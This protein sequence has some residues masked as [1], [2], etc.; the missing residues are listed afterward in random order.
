MQQQDSQPARIITID[1]KHLGNPQVIATYLLLGDEP[2]LVDP[3]P[4]AT[5]PNLEAGLATQGL[6]LSDIRTILLTHI[7]LDH[8][9]ATGTIVARHPH[10][11]VYVHERGAGHIIDPSRLLN[12]A[13][14]LYGSMMDTLWGDILPVR[15]DA[16]TTLQGGETLAVGRRTVRV[17][18]AP[19]HAKHHVIYL[20]EESGGAFVG[21]NG[22]VRLPGLHFT[23]PATPPPDVDLDAWER[24]L[25]LLE[26]L[27]PDW[28]LLTH[29]GAYPD[30]LHHLRDYRERLLRWGEYVRQGLTRG[31]DEATQI[32]GLENMAA[33]ETSKLSEIE[34]SRLRQQ[35]GALALSWRGLARY[36]RKRSEVAE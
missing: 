5:L 12:S 31:D 17:F 33:A 22:G 25:D 26:E 18:D 24:T 34:Q 14:Q 8:A 9:G 21:D 35:T 2:A 19:G 29:F 15:A 6:Q 16:I 7:H 3:G 11:R 30:V 13:G 27:R 36:W 1:D 10:V 20:D 23:R 32:I 28:L 4:T